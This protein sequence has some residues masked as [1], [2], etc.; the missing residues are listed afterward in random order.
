[1]NGKQSLI[2][3]TAALSLSACAA[4]RNMLGLGDAPAPPPSQI[5]VQTNNPLALP[6]DLALRQPSAANTAYQ[7]NTAA[8]APLDANGD[9]FATAP[10]APVARAPVRDVY[11][12]YGV[13][14]TNPDGSAKDGTQL[15]K[16]LKAAVLRRKQQQNPNYGTI[17]NMGSIF[18]DG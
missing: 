13:S 9:D 5:T 3:L 15:Q 7:A 2:I 14:K 12:E 10:A 18:S 1:M 11:A 6:P 4:S 8:T 17:F 16:E